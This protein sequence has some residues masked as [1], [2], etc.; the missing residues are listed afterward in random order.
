MVNI[1]ALIIC[2]FIHH[3]NTM[4]VAKAM[5]DVLDAEIKKPSEVDVEEVAE[6]DLIGFGS[7]VYNRKLHR[8]LSELINRLESQNHTNAFIFST[9]YL[10]FKRMHKPLKSSLIDRGFNVIGEFQCK[11]SMKDGFISRIFGE[12]NKGKPNKEDL[13][14]AK[15]FAIKM[16]DSC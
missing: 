13:K 2:Q 14:K 11:G 8:S 6:Y 15:D 3:G 9:A 12:V 1:K 5:A 10:P 7:G 16:K 4:K